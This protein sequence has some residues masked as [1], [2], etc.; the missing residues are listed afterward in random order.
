M[1]KSLWKKYSTI[2]TKI[3]D[4]KNIELNALPLYGY[5]Y[6]KTKVRT[7]SDKV[8]TNSCGLNVPEDEIECESFTVTSTDY[9]LV[10]KNKYCLQVYLEN[11]AYKVIIEWMTDYLDDNL[12]ETN[13]D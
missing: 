11:C 12:L 6:I 13:E 9:L 4:L 3:E 1:R 8:Y 10:Y 7:Y 5:G 2:W